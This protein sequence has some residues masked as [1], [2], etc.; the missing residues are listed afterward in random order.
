MCPGLAGI[1]LIMPRDR[2]CLLGCPGPV[3]TVAMR[4]PARQ[5]SLWKLTR[6]RKAE[7]PARKWWD[8]LHPFNPLP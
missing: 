5:T 6:A 8:E 4:D 1:F 7:N 2:P 3:W